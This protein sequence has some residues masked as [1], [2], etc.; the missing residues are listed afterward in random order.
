MADRA[1]FVGPPDEP[2]FG[3]LLLPPWWGTTSPFRRRADALADEGF[4]VL[5]PDLNFGA[6][7]GTEAEAS[8]VLN[9]ADP[10]RLAGMVQASAGLL[11]QR[12]DGERIAVVGF[13]MG[14]SL[15]LWLSVRR[16]DLVTAAVSAYGHQAIDFKGS[17]A[18]YQLH[19]AEDD[20]F[21][22][23]DDAAFLEATMRMERLD[24]QVVEHAGTISGFADDSGP[25]FDEQAAADLWA[26]VVAFLHEA[27]ARD[28]VKGVLATDSPAAGS[29]GSPPDDAGA[30]EA[31]DDMADVDRDANGN[32]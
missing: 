24:V 28:E 1:Y 9:D 15:G 5:A 19:F 4:T 32:T 17:E 22:S 3:V 31:P 13:G 30:G 10:D 8:E 27:A 11:A 2:G 18:R 14:G 23:G 26:E 6:R 12:S 21:I 25:N 16:P 20:E 29:D 7:P